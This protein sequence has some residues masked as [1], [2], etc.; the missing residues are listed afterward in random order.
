[1]KIETFFLFSDIFAFVE[2][3]QKLEG[4]KRNEPQEDDDMGLD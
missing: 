3:L 2:A 1:M 4:N